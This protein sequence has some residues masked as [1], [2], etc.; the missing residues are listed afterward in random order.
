MKIIPSID[1]FDGKV[2]RLKQ[3]NP[4]LATFYD[5]N[6]LDLVE[7]WQKIAY[8]DIGALGLRKW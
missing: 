6:P 8:G 7:K 5:Y 2:V 4:E 1:L 3:G